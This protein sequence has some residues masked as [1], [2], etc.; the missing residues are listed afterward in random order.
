MGLYHHARNDFQESISY[1]KQALAINPSQVD[2][3][4][5]LH[6]SYKA[7]G[8]FRDSLEVSEEIRLRDPMYIPGIAN[9]AELYGILGRNEEAI[10]LLEGVSPMFPEEVQDRLWVKAY[11][12]MPQHQLISTA[13]RL[14]SAQPNNSIGRLILGI[15][16][17]DIEN[18]E[19]T[20]EVA[21]DLPPA[22]GALNKLGR[23]EEAI[24]LAYAMAAEGQAVPELIQVLHANKKYD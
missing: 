1:L 12:A 4:N 8:H 7:L 2:A 5:W 23:T 16:H 17:S 15:Y 14:Y 9:L 11:F 6:N 10:A 19:R 20:L 21:R 13:E 3:L 22:I 24:L 18:P